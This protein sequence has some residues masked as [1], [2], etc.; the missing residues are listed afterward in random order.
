[1]LIARVNRKDK[2]QFLVHEGGEADTLCV[3]KIEPGPTGMTGAMFSI[4]GKTF[5]IEE[6]YDGG[7][8]DSW[9][10]LVPGGSESEAR[11]TVLNDEPG[12]VCITTSFGI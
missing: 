1:M 10:L 8:K 11:A 2:D 7:G 5:N 6:A 4:G 3:L 12:S 9:E